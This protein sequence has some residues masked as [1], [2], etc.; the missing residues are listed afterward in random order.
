MM[1]YLT[2]SSIFMLSGIAVLEKILKL[3]TQKYYSCYYS[4]TLPMNIFVTQMNP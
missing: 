1:Q 4:R 2:F 3:R